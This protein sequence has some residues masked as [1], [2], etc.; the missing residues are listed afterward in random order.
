ML[1]CRLFEYCFVDKDVQNPPAIRQFGDTMRI[2]KRLYKSF[3]ACFSTYSKLPMPYVELGAR[4]SSLSLVFFPLVGVVIGLFEYLWGYAYSVLT[5][6][7]MVYAMIAAVIPVIITGGI[8]IDGYMDTCDAF[9]SYADKEKKLEIMKDPRTG[10]FAVIY[11]AVFGLLYISF[12]NMLSEKGIVFFCFSFVFSRIFSGIS[13]CT[14]NKAKREGMIYSIQKYSD[15][16]VVF[17]CLLVMFAIVSIV[18]TFISAVATGISVVILI[19]MYFLYRDKCEKTI[20]GI[21]GDTSGAYLCV[22][23]LVLLLVSVIV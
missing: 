14:I 4:D 8:H 13:V 17:Y 9:N 1:Q 7:T 15:N 5:V 18:A 20:G 21:T 11:L 6:S 3:I 10:A 23:E 19:L 22:M 16:R 12:L 2:I